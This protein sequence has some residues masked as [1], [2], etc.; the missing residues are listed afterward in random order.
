[1]FSSNVFITADQSPRSVCGR[2][3]G[4]P[5]IGGKVIPETRGDNSLSD[6]ISFNGGGGNR[7][8]EWIEEDF[9]GSNR[10]EGGWLSFVKLYSTFLLVPIGVGL[11]ESGLNLLSSLIKL[12]K[13][14]C[15]FSLSL[16]VNDFVG[17]IDTGLLFIT[18]LSEKRGGIKD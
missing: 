12:F 5:F 6:V 7:G 3:S 11:N 14:N 9:D 16:C 10:V 18:L 15:D 17:F 1:M 2:L 8:D 4:R 13:G